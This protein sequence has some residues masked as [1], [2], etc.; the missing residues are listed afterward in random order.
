MADFRPPFLERL[1]VHDPAA[2]RAFGWALPMAAFLGV[3]AFASLLDVGLGVA[4]LGGLAAFVGGTLLIGGAAALFTH[5]LAR[6][7]A[8]LLL[9]SGV[10]SAGGEEFSR[11][12]ALVA[13]GK[14]DVAL[15]LMERRR[16]EEPGNVALL[17]LLADT[18]ARDAGKPRRA[19]PLFR[20]ARKLKGCSAGEDL[21]A[22][23][24]LVDL[25]LGPLGQPGAAS[26]ELRRIVER[27]PRS[28]AAVEV[29]RRVG[30]G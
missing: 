2:L 26:R 10:S 4:L 12:R 13:A 27:H 7:G 25:Y 30:E 19:E 11:E 15:A 1:G 29:R 21:Y 18:Y 9:P 23:N 14:L 22:T 3:L 24:R 16:E 5:L 20:A 6:G 17:L 8:G 28:R